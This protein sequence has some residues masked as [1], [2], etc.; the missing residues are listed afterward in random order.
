MESKYYNR[1][2]EVF[3]NFKTLYFHGIK[4][5]EEDFFPSR[6]IDSLDDCKYCKF[7]INCYQKQPK[8]I[9]DDKNIHVCT[10]LKNGNF[11]STLS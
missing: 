3:D 7:K 10:S 8:Y 4:I 5:N 2:K 1:V 9:I 6:L 11:T